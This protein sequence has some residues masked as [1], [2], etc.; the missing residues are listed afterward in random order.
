MAKPMHMSK[1]SVFVLLLATTILVYCSS[2]RKAAKAPVSFATQVMPVLQNSCTPCHFN[3][4][5]KRLYFNNIDT[6]RRNIDDIIRR[7]QLP[8]DHKDFMPFKLKKPALSDTAIN[9]L[10]SWKE[11]GLMQ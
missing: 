2:S 5:G 6:V 8:T 1:A 4:T 7:V 3:E 10:K 11:T 9:T